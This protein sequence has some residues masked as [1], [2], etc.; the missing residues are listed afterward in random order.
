MLLLHP[1]PSPALHT[2]SGFNCSLRQSATVV[3]RA[4]P[5]ES[6]A[7]I[8]HLAAVSLSRS[9]RS[10]VLISFSS[11]TSSV[12]LF[13]LSAVVFVLSSILPSFA[14][15]LPRRECSHSTLLE[16]LLTC[17]F[18][19]IPTVRQALF[20]GRWCLSVCYGNWPGSLK[21]AGGLFFLKLADALLASRCDL[22]LL[23][24]FVVLCEF[25]RVFAD[26]GG[27]TRTNGRCE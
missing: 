7:L 25:C 19:I 10:P 3:A 23:V 8:P 21:N 4:W 27:V 14:R 5:G 24:V 6:Q 22:S 17:Y 16:C 20:R 15:C 11:A 12:P 1:S 13:Q 9:R 2:A 26:A 18:I